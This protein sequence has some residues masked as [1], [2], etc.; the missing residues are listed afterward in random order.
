MQETTPL[1]PEE[2]GSQQRGPR[3]ATFFQARRPKTIYFLLS[4]MVFG[5]SFSGSLGE[6]P[7][8]RLTEDNLC[9]RYY[10][11]RLDGKAMENG[12]DE[13]LCKIDEIQ[14]QLAY[15]NGWLPM[16][17]AVIGESVIWL[18]VFDGRTDCF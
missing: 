6:V 18:R 11:T 8:T 7:I 10:S 2:G 5:L 3:N 13:S 14:S 12:I 1:L 9:R 4:L 17:E 16:I 15:L